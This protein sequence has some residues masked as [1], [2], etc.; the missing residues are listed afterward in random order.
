M[1]FQQKRRIKKSI[2]KKE[3]K[4]CFF[5]FSSDWLFPTSETKTILSA[6][7]SINANSS[8]IEDNTDKGHDAFL[9]D[10]PEFHLSLEKFIKGQLKRIIYDKDIKKRF[11][12]ISNLIEKMK[13]Y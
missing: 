5:F 1:I 3:L 11:I 8:F 9:L 2:F 7:K 6:L 13:E 4:Y 12:K 10:E